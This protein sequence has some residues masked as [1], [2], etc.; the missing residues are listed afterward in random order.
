MI[1]R[2]RSYRDGCRWWREFLLWQYPIHLQTEIANRWVACKVLTVSSL[3][4][5][6]VFLLPCTSVV[7]LVRE[8][9]APTFP[10][11]IRRSRADAGA[12]P[13]GGSRKPSF[14]F[15]RSNRHCLLLHQSIDTLDLGQTFAI[16]QSHLIDFSRF[17]RY[18][19][20]DEQVKYHNE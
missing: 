19:V 7:V 14:K 15:D 11:R 12:L 17:L 5:V 2:W 8:R 20:I 16:R 6:D 9:L 18:I 1:A 4:L 10:I 3:F 13:R